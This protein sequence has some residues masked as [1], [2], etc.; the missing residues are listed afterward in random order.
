MAPAGWRMAS[1]SMCSARKVSMWAPSGI[2]IAAQ[3]GLWLERPTI[4]VAKSWLYGRYVEPGP[5]RGDFSPLLTH[6]QPQ[7]VIGAAVRSRDNTKPLFVS[8]GHL[9]DVDHA[10]DF[11]LRCVT[12]YRLPEPTRWAHKVAG[13]EAFPAL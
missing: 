8:P 13:G 9:M 7:R 6:T 4:G 1:S 5:A 12:R 3:M 11:V 10:V 2:G